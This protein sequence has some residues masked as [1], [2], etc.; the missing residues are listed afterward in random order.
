MLPTEIFIL[1]LKFTFGWEGGAENDP[2][3]VGG[4]TTWGIT[5]A[6]AR[7]YGYT[8]DMKDLDQQT[9]ALIYRKNYFDALNLGYVDDVS[10]CKRMFDYAV[11]CGAGTA[12]KNLQSVLNRNNNRGTYWPDLVVDGDLGAVTLGVLRI[13]LSIPRH[14][15]HVLF[16]LDIRRGQ[17]YETDTVN[18]LNDTNEKY[19]PGWENRLAV[20]MAESSALVI[21][22]G[23]DAI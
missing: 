16:S 13:A 23:Q 1:C 15:A 7:A 6:V 9:A 20:L 18:P 3:D 17:T 10:F 5:E 21:Q 14:R 8:G 4:A 11:N 2:D 12:A 19:V 22:H